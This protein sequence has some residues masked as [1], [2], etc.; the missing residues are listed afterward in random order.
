[1]YIEELIIEGFKSYATRTV[2]SGWDR[3]FNAITGL[4]GSGKS[5]ILDAICFV[6]GISNLS[7][8]RAI[9]LQDLIYK[10]GQ[11]GITKATVTIVFNNAETKTSPIGYEQFKEIT[12][13]RQIL[14]GGKTKYLINGHLAQQR[15]VMNLFQSVQLN[16]NN[17]HFLIMQGKITKV[18][19]MKPPE[20]LAMVEEAAGTRMFED[21]K[22]LATKIIEKKDKKLEDINRILNEYI[23]PD[24]EKK[25]KERTA[26]LEYQKIESEVERLTKFCLA[27]TYMN[28]QEIMKKTLESIEKTRTSIRN[29]QEHM[30]CL[31]KEI[32]ELQ[33]QFQQLAEK[34]EKEAGGNFSRLEKEVQRV[35]EQLVRFSTQTELKKE[36]L[37]DETK[38]HDQLTKNRV[39]LETTRSGKQEAF[40]MAKSKLDI[41]KALVEE[42]DALLKRTEET[43]QALQ[44][45]LSETDGSDGSYMGRLRE[46]KSELQTITTEMKQIKMKMDHL[47]KELKEK[48]LK[49]KKFDRENGSLMEDFETCSREIGHLQLKI[50]KLGFDA[51]KENEL[52]EQKQQ[53]KSSVDRLQQVLS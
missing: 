9:N 47:R 18:L 5:N 25:R 27:H 43:L 19:N 11:A 37:G 16:V 23:H 36:S 44:T 31:K 40:K 29:S 13:T 50:E 6:L 1:M 24:L 42:K 7:Q 21:K 52:K 49:A 41:T 14:M 10:R 51:T 20:I 39:E 12:V 48:E 45:G 28:N 38:R 53:K 4:N 3:E 33:V 22:E 2:I 30:T 17:P 35:S 8:V 46:A 34:R 32:D 15:S 26:F